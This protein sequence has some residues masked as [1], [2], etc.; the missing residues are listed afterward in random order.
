MIV[1]RIAS[2]IFKTSIGKVF[3]IL[4]IVGIL[5]FGWAT[6]QRKQSDPP[7]IPDYFQLSNSEGLTVERSTQSVPLF[8]ISQL[9]DS[10]ID[11]KAVVGG[12]LIKRASEGERIEKGGL[13]AELSN[14][15]LLTKFSKAKSELSAALM[16]TRF[17]GAF[18]KSPEYLELID[19]QEEEERNLIWAKKEAEQ[20]VNARYTAQRPTI[21]T[22]NLD[23][24]KLGDVWGLTTAH[25]IHAMAHWITVSGTE[26]RYR[27]GNRVSR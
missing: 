24:E 8:F 1:R 26:L 15:E 12:I 19:K 14:D 20:L 5:F 9:D 18:N 10:E 4:C 25:R 13:I 2:G 6:L 3:T 7:G 16:L 27:G 23:F 11:V 22:T 17:S 21:F